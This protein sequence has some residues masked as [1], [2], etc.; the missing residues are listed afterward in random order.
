MIKYDVISHRRQKIYNK[1]MQNTAFPFVHRPEVAYQTLNYFQIVCIVIRRVLHAIFAA[2]C[3][4]LIYFASLIGY[5]VNV[6]LLICV[7]CVANL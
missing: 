7:R 6:K 5:C 1:C 4:Y 3:C 2:D